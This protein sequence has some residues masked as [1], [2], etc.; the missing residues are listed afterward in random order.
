MTKCLVKNS[1]GDSINFLQERGQYYIQHTSDGAVFTL[2][3]SF[4]DIQEFIK[5]VAKI[6]IEED[7]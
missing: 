7:V 4:G 6:S 1:E 5:N 3:L 2:R